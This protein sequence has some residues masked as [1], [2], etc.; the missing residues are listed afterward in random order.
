M[1]TTASGPDL[2]IVRAG[3][4][5]RSSSPYLQGVTRW[6]L[7]SNDSL[8][9]AKHHLPQGTHVAQ[10]QHQQD[11]LVYM[12]SGRLR[13]QVGDQTFEVVAGD[14]LIVRGGVPHECWSEEDTVSLDIFHPTRPDFIN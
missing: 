7:A 1:A 8:L 10:H 9:L 12:I 14:S 4:A 11:Q 6:V 5:Q 2:V 13:W 3:D